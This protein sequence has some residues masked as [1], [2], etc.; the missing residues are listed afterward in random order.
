MNCPRIACATGRKGTLPAPKTVRTPLPFRRSG[1][2]NRE[3]PRGLLR[4]NGRTVATQL[5]VWAPT[6]GLFV[7]LGST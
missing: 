6:F 4:A 7:G 2:K 5:L 3:A 1:V